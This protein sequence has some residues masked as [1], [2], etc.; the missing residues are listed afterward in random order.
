[1]ELGH[2]YA[3]HPFEGNRCLVHDLEH[4]V[5]AARQ[6][7]GFGDLTLRE[8]KDL[9]LH[10]GQGHLV[11]GGVP[12]VPT[13]LFRG[14]TVGRALPRQLPKVG[15]S[16][17]QA[18]DLLGLFPALDLDLATHDCAV[19]SGLQVVV[20]DFPLFE[21]D[22]CVHFPGEELVHQ[23]LG[24]FALQLAAQVAVAVPSP[25]CRFPN[26]DLLVDQGLQML[27]SPFDAR[28]LGPQAFD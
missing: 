18:H 1:M 22:L 5:G 11:L 19:P 2:H 14:R 3:P 6:G 23:P 4:A 26:E 7:Y 10:D 24:P 20:V 9:F 27:P 16:L 12:G 13:A 28:L 21:R 8:W 15:T 25:R 17:Q